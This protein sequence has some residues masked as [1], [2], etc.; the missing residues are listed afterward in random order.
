MSTPGMK[1]VTLP[2]LAW[3]GAKE[4]PL[5][6]PQT[7]ATTVYN[8]AGFDQPAMR[9]DEIKRSIADPIGSPPIRELARG[10]KKVAIVFDDQTRVTKVAEIV[11]YVLEELAEAGVPDSGIQFVCATGAH[12]AWDRVSLAKKVGE[13][14]LLRFPVYNHNP[15]DNCVYVG[16]TTHGNRVCVNAEVMKCDL[17]IAIGSVVPHHTTGFGGGGKIVLPGISSMETIERFH[18][19]EGNYKANEVYKPYMGMGLFDD[20]PL[21]LEVE[22]AARLAG[23]DIKIDCLVNTWG[24]TVGIHAGSPGPAFEAAVRDAKAHYRTPDAQGEEIIIANTFAKANEAIIVGLHIAFK[25]LSPEGGDIVLIGNAPDGQVAHYLVGPW[26]K[27]TGG[28]I[29]WSVKLPPHVNRLIYFS[30]YTDI[31]CKG[32][33]GESSKVLPLNKWDDVVQALVSSY[34]TGARVAIYPNADIQY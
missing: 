17:R 19:L 14:T 33:F 20:N 16:T 25:S 21:R 30:E 18:S 7:W 29:A 3:Y 12:M 9:P 24:E 1:R 26:G 23:L 13:E 2:Q 11:P 22:E 10:K 15:F 34:G 27:S 4:L 32:Y 28:R 6:L 8:M 5:T 31:A